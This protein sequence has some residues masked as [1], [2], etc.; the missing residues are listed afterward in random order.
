MGSNPTLISLNFFPLGVRASHGMTT[1]GERKIRTDGLVCVPFLFEV[2][3]GGES[4][5]SWLAGC[6]V[7]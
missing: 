5:G 2:S 6:V 7:M 4:V 1:S 3:D